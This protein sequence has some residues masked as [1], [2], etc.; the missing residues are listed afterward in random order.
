[1]LRYWLRCIVLQDWSMAGLYIYIYIYIY[2]YV[3]H[4]ISF[5]T[6]SVQAFKIVVEYTLL[7]TDCHSC[8]ISKMPSG[9]ED[10]LEE[11]YVIKFC[12]KLNK[13]A[14]DTYGKLQTS[15]Q[16]SCMN[17]ASVFEWHKRFK[18]GRV[19]VMMRVVIGVR[20]SDHQSRLAKGLGL[21]FWVTTLR[22]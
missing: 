17:R 16:P 8:W 15:F 19:S 9:C 1:M 20:K 12:S 2:I 6:F 18:E 22:F 5:N 14:I 4:S 11:R 3:V 10:T 7:K 21:G 13:N